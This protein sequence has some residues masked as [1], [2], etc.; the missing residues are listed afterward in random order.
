MKIALILNDD[1]SMWHFR[2]G[3]ISALAKAGH[4]VT[5]ITPDGPYVLRIKELKI[6]HISIPMYRFF[7]PLKDIALFFRFLRCFLRN[8]FDL[9]HTMTIKPNIYGTLAAKL[10]GVSQIVCLISGMGFMFSTEIYQQSSIITALAHKLYKFSLTFA[11]RIWFQNL[12]DL[13]YF[14][15]K[16]IIPQYKALVIKSGGI[17]LDEYTPTTVSPEE[18]KPLRQEMQFS[19]DEII[20]SMIT[21]RMVWSKGVGEFI[22]AAERLAHQQGVKFLLVGPVE[23]NSPDVVPETY[24]KRKNGTNLRILPT[25]RKDIK[26]ILALSD[27]VVLPSYYREGV[28][29]ILLEAMAM[30]K[31]VVTTNHV[32]CKEVVD[33]GVNGYLVPIRNAGALAAAIDRLLVDRELRIAFGRNSLKKVESEFAESLVITQILK[34]LYCIA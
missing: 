12:E 2:K 14:V 30:G 10:A 13:K 3:L 27:I 33:D 25:F 23:G 17:N 11:E 15:T 8:R 26:E 21:A 31:P 28:P 1:F 18:L 19:D 29:R 22:D 24:L 5:V 7:S 6:R 20:V 34:K 32:G 16:G 9:V 4:E